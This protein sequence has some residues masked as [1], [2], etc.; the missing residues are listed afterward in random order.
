MIFADE[1]TGN[2]DSA[3]GRVV[4]DILLGLNRDQGI[5][6]VLVT[7]DDELA[8]RMDRQVYLSDG[9]VVDREGLDVDERPVRSRRPLVP[10]SEP[11]GGASALTLSPNGD[12]HAAH[13]VAGADSER[14]A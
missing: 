3:T 2:L 14:V 9:R 13:A 10:R 11:V 7:H 6:L 4:Q 5:T 1:P 12:R 8:Q